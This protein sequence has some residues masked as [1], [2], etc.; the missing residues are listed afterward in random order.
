M[1][2]NLYLTKENCPNWR[3]EHALKELIDMVSSK[4]GTISLKNFGEYSYLVLTTPKPFI[5]VEEVLSGIGLEKNEI[6]DE[7]TK[8]ALLVLLREN[9]K[10]YFTNKNI[11]CAF[12]FRIPRGSHIEMLHLIPRPTHELP[13]QGTTIEI[14]NVTQ[15]ELEKIR[16]LDNIGFMKEDKELLKKEINIVESNVKKSVIDLDAIL[17]K[18][19]SKMSNLTL[20]W[21]FLEKEEME[22]WIKGEGIIGFVR[23]YLERNQID[24]SKYAKDERVIKYIKSICLD[25]YR[26]YSNR[27]ITL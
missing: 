13:I 24:L 17:D 22:K 12:D 16:V 18:V 27:Y 7:G 6:I 11:I 5:S 21:Y 25:C 1:I 15:E 3:K 4:D 2:H 8:L 26:Q 20:Q 19:F 14:Q 9:I 23:E 10:F